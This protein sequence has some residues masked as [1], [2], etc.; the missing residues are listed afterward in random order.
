MAA[1]RPVIATAYSGNLEFMTE[2][3]AY[4]VPYELTDIPYGCAPYTPGT[5]WA[6]PDVDAAAAAMR[7]VVSDRAQARSVGMQAYEHIRNHHGV[8]SRT[9]FVRGRLDAI[10]GGG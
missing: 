6:E 3:T 10:R 2:E 1:A 8:G 7:A 9:A 5:P 4:F